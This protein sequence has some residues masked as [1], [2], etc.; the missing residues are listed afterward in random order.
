MLYRFNYCYKIFIH[1]AF[2]EEPVKKN[3]GGW[4]QVDINE[5][6]DTAATMQD[7]VCNWFPN[8]SPFCFYYFYYIILR[9]LR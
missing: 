9:F 7:E 2:Q 5:P 8:K 1:D 6:M 4:E 3:T